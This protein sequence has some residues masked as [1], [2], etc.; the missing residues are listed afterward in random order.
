MEA[1]PSIVEPFMSDPDRAATM[2][3]AGVVGPP[4]VWVS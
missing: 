1:D 2:Q 3:A 4:Q